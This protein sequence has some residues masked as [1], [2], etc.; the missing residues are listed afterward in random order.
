MI[1]DLS[2]LFL[3]CTCFVL[4]TFQ[5][6]FLSHPCL[7][8]HTFSFANRLLL[9]SLLF[10]FHTNCVSSVVRYH[11]WSVKWDVFLTHLS[12][13][14]FS[15][16]CWFIQSVCFIIVCFWLLCILVHAHTYLPSRAYLSI[17]N[18]FLVHLHSFVFILLSRSSS[19]N[20]SLVNDWQWSVKKLRGNRPE[21]L[22]FVFLNCCA[23]IAAA[24]T[25]SI[26]ILSFQWHWGG[27]FM[28]KRTSGKH[29]TQKTVEN[30]KKTF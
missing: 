28:L 25:A 4:N 23:T 13:S 29:K 12:S 18:S 3:V 20:A 1:I 7:C 30:E 27:I 15:F 11:S 5:S 24:A 2:F 8:V 17:S 14:M 26:L 6:S 9:F 10:R 19:V 16:S 22:L 21:Q